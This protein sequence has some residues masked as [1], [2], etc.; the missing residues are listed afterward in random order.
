MASISKKYIAQLEKE[1]EGGSLENLVGVVSSV[2][3]KKALKQALEQ[4]GFTGLKEKSQHKT[5]QLKRM[6]F[7]II[8]V[9]IINS[10]RIRPLLSLD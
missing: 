7:P 3:S 9:I 2:K 10:K 6:T 5:T 8:Q 1:M 4:Y